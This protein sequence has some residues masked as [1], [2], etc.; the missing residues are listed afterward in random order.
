MSQGSVLGP[1][2]FNIFINDL[3]GGVEG[4]L[5]KFAHYRYTKV[6]G[7]A[8]ATEDRIRIQIDLNRLEN[9]A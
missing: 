1:L 5:I 4:M 7:V 8:N 6:G 9:W 2:L 3:D